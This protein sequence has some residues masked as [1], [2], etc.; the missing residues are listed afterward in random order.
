MHK[1]LLV[2]MFGLVFVNLFCFDAKK[3]TKNSKNKKQKLLSGFNIESSH[4][5]NSDQ[6]F[7]SLENTL[8]LQKSN[9]KKR[10]CSK[11]KMQIFSN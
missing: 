1:T 9:K 5:L 8:H 2:F 7:F 10:K 4:R 11:L 3:L 6:V